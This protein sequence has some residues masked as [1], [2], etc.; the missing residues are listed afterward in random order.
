MGDKI[1][2][3]NSKTTAFTNNGWENL[4]NILCRLMKDNKAE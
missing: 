1:L 4:Q 3:V 2:L